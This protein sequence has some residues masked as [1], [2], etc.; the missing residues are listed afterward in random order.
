LSL[1]DTLGTILADFPNRE[2]A[3]SVTIHQLLTHTAGTGDFLMNPQFR[4]SRERY[5]TTADYLSLVAGETLAFEPGAR[6]QYSNSGYVLLGAVIEQLSGES[7]F[8]YVQAHI[9]QPAGMN[10]TGYFE[11]NETV[12]RRAVGYLRDPAEDPFGIAPRRSNVMFI[13][14]KGNSAGGGYSTAGD[15]FRFAR[16][17]R[18]GRLLSATAVENVTAGKVDMIGAPRPQRYGYG[19]ATRTIGEKEVRGMSGGGPSSGV[20]SSL[21]I[22]WDGSYTV[23]VVG[24]YDSPAAE[25]LNEKICEFLAWQ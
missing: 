7:Y 14:F 23:V 3:E 9:F 17:L 2:I 15:L 18:G 13:P 12:S 5:R 6:W 20:N 22:F 19:F 16:A 24:N 25:E 21:E 1:D 4:A 10:E 8:D 11:L